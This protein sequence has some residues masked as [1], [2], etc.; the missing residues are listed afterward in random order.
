MFQQHGKK[1]TADY[2]PQ[3]EKFKICQNIKRH[4]DYEY[5]DAVIDEISTRWQKTRFLRELYQDSAVFAEF[6][7]FR[8]RF[9]SVKTAQE[10]FAIV[11]PGFQYAISTTQGFGDVGASCCDEFKVNFHKTLCLH[12]LAIVTRTLAK[13]TELDTISRSKMDIEEIACGAWAKSDLPG[14]Y[15][16][17]CVQLR[18]RSLETWNFLYHFLLR[19][20]FPPIILDDW[21]K[22]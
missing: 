19:K 6:E 20:L 22:A 11:T 17:L 1:P 2:R 18:T 15:S 16:E 13:A 9:L 4:V 14:V 5:T 12:S 3:K 10:T 21:I 7:D 8:R